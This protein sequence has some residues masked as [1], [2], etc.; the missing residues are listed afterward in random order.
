MDS[1]DNDTY[2]SEFSTVKE[3][4]DI[5]TCAGLH[6][7]NEFLSC[8]VT[9]RGCQSVQFSESIGKQVFPMCSLEIQCEGIEINEEGVP[10]IGI[11]GSFCLPSSAGDSLESGGLQISSA[12]GVAA[13]SPFSIFSG[14]SLPCQFEPVHTTDDS[15]FPCVQSLVHVDMATPPCFVFEDAT[16]GVSGSRD[17]SNTG[18]Q[19]NSSETLREIYDVSFQYGG[20]WSDPLSV[21]SP[22]S[23][24]VYFFEQVPVFCSTNPVLDVGTPYN[25]HVE[26]EIIQFEDNKGEVWVRPCGKVCDGVHFLDGCQLQLN[27]CVFYDK[28]FQNKMVDPNTNYILDGIFHG[29]KIVDE[30]YIG[31]YFCSNYSSILLPQPKQEMSDILVKKTKYRQGVGS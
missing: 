7:E 21:S 15:T 25:G 13:C 22:V 8:S 23:S 1:I 2:R 4:C 10:G 24:K 28:C 5:D 20:I 27:P 30:D 3:H 14:S 26:S 9:S 29:F 17:G 6:S 18:S 16:L 11:D 19:F 31:S 12:E